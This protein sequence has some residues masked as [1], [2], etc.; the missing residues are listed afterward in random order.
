MITTCLRG[1]GHRDQGKLATPGGHS[2]PERALADDPAG[3]SRA[4]QDRDHHPHILVNAGRVLATVLKMP[5]DEIDEYLQVLGEIAGAS[6]GRD[7]GSAA[8]GLAPREGSSGWLAVA[9]RWPGLAPAGAGLGRCDAGAE[10][11]GGA[12]G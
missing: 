6:R 10:E 12:A 4:R 3:A 9:A 2:C 8:G 5:E 11:A 1:A 7:H